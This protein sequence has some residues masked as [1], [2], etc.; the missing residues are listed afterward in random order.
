M[1]SRRSPS[2]ARAAPPPKRG[3]Q[4]DDLSP[5]FTA[6]PAGFVL[7]DSQLRIL[8]ANAE[9]A[10]ILGSTVPEILGKTPQDVAPL[11]APTV[12]PIL[13]KVF[14]TGKP[15]LNFRVSGETP[16]SPG[17]IR[18]WL[19]SVF[20]VPRRK[21]QKPRIG[22]VAIEVTSQ[23]RFERMSKDHSLL[24]QAEEMARLGSWEHDCATGN[25]LWSPNLCRIL[26]RTEPEGQLS[27][28]EFWASLHP[29]DREMVRG[30]IDGAMREKLPYEYRARFILPDGR[31]RLLHTRARVILDS[32]NRLVRRFGVTQDITEKVE[33]ERK[34]TTTEERYRDLVENSADLICTHDLDGTL[35]S[36]NDRPAR[37]LGYRPE[38]LIGRRI[39]DI[40]L[41]QYRDQFAAYIATLRREAHVEGLVS[42]R[43]RDGE[44]RVWEYRNTLRTV[45]VEIPI[46]RGF[47]RDVTDKLRAERAIQESEALATQHL[48]E[49]N[50]IYDTAPVGLCFVDRDLRYVRVN[51]VL[52]ATNGLPASAHIGRSIREVIPDLA[53]QVVPMYAG[54]FASGQPIQNVELDSLASSEPWAGH[55]WNVSIIPLK[56]QAGSILGCN[57]VVQDITPLKKAEAALRQL[58]SQLIHIQDQERHRISRALHETLAQDLAGLQMLLGQIARKDPRLSPA[59]RQSLHECSTINRQVMAQIRTLSYLLHP[60]SLETGDLSTTLKWYISGFSE[61]SEILIDLDVPETFGPL[62]TEYKLVLFRVMQECL[63]NVHRHS[64]SSWAGVR[65]T[66]EGHDVRME[67]ADRGKGMDLNPSNNSNTPAGIGILEM[68]ERVKQLRGSFQIDAAPGRGVRV[69]VDLHIQ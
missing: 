7:M 53:P 52:A 42:V 34:L 4:F 6:A 45:G 13:L 69:R 57:V 10:D 36:M 66:R 48:A 56:D 31:E 5:F 51:D 65:L 27:Q 62:P 58:S 15:K 40:L 35:L 16:K 63:T 3:I 24:T 54:V 25:E 12:E 38:D 41:P 39:P 20:L 21:N 68:R 47:A 59:I 19:A 9:M 26:G 33:T 8:R 55:V 2:I 14:S 32:E 46:V 67:I 18:H 30:V 60:P 23:A 61:R 44:R 1:K 43:T 28:S 64:R 29:G 50:A 17:V 11:L 22:G 49:L 37:L